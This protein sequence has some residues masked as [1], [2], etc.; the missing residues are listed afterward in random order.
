M[1]FFALIVG[2]LL[3]F[4]VPGQTFAATANTPS[5]LKFPPAPGLSDL[6]ADPALTVGTLPNG[7]SYAL[8]SNPE[9]RGR[10]ALRLIVAAGSLH[11]TEAQRGL[12]HFLEHLAFNGSTHYPPGTLVEFFQRMGMNFGGDTNAYTSFDRT[13]YML[14]LPDA[15]PATLAEGLRVLADYAGELLL[16]PAEIDHERGVVLSEKL[17]RDSADY[18]AAVAGYEFFYAG[19]LLPARLPIGLE[20]VI[21]TATR[22]DFADF[23]NTWY[24]PER[25]AVVAIGDLDPAVVE[26]Q[27][28]DLF[29]PLAARG[30]A[31]PEPDLG[32][33]STT[34]PRFGH[35]FEPEA[36]AT[37]VTLS[38]LLPPD[39][40]PD[41]A[42]KRLR[43]LPRDLAFDLLNRRFAELAKTETA[44]FV[45]AAAGP[46]S[47]PGIHDG[48]ELQ[49]TARP[50]KWTDTLR[51]GDNEL[52]RALQFGFT[53]AELREA[54]AS[55]QNRLEQALKTDA[56]RRSEERADELVDAF[57]EGTIPTTPAAD[58]AL[59]APALAK[60]T[61]ADLLPAFRAAWGDPGA[62]RL[63]VMGNT[64]LGDT[65]AAASALI[66]QTYIAATA[67]EVT[68]PA[69]RTD[70]AW[71]YNDFGTAGK[72]TSRTEVADLGITQLVFANGVRVN[73]KPT[74]FEAGS[75]ALRARVGTGQLTE[76]HDQ[77]GLA[78]F[79]GAAF[80]AGGL[81]RHSADELRRILAGRNVGVGL[82]IGEDALVFSGKTTPADLDLQLQLLTAHLT[83]PGYRPEAQLTVRRQLE[84]FF[85]RLATQPN[86][87]L[88]QQ[89][90][91]LL[92]SGDPRFGLPARDEALARTLDELR[93]WLAP[94]LA[95]P[96]ELS[97]VG[98]FD[99]EKTIPALAATLGTLPARPAKPALEE[100]RRV[101]TPPPGTFTLTYQGSIVKNLLAVYWPTTDAR[102]VSR[103]RRLNLLS[104]IL[105]D[106]L[107]TA[108]REELGG[109]YSP[110]AGNAPS[111]SYRDRGFILAQV[112]TDP[113]E[114]EAVRKAVLAAAADL[115]AHGVKDDELIRARQPL[116]TSLQE[117]ERTN[118]YWLTT[119]LGAAQEQPWRI[120]WSRTRR[121]DYES[122]TKAELDVL[123]RQ[124][125]DPARALQF[126]IV[127]APAPA[128]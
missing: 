12:A 13:V 67:A 36:S 32:T 113:P 91:R 48:A 38:N 77:P 80:T 66:A 69:E 37:T 4:A 93:T 14:D 30:P 24:R 95:G 55:Y 2:L 26:K 6:A 61:P 15:K 42:Q 85:A 18:R 106:R 110:Q 16:Q 35:H 20:P 65:P 124:Y 59:L 128:K 62:R 29:S 41:S 51:V 44:P 117:S 114:I 118:A 92:A 40:S 45:K 99:V 126:N 60:L 70:A 9:P 101:P 28:R 31:R 100:L 112:L 68:A 7:L 82:Q 94:Q 88:N 21:K 103:T 25:L 39:R 76:P 111:E 27:L 121:A 17:A 43:D 23:Y 72:I 86:G 52:R 57:I 3:S 102:D 47:F 10:V 107:R 75:I 98:A 81:G 22:P 109:S 87:A 83:D 1:R 33:P 105:S 116:L 122:I 89:V 8:R 78:F 54:V 11:E 63:A 53:A 84:P 64:R 120:E 5:A 58:L 123:A 56:T 119:V 74:D 96:V 71:A 79:G 49:L 97:L 108:V 125:L 115:S 46:D 90:P 34:G 104:E 50:G 19:T 127:P 73:L